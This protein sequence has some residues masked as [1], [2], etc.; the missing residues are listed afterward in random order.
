[1]LDLSVENLSKSAEYAKFLDAFMS[2][3]RYDDGLFRGNNTSMV[4]MIVHNHHDAWHEGRT[5]YS[6]PVAN[7]SECLGS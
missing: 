7:K 1:M 5:V 2:A 3:W 6:V 4:D